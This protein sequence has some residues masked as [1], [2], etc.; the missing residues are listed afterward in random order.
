MFDYA[1]FFDKFFHF[2]MDIMN[3]YGLIFVLSISLYPY[4]YV[5]S[6]AFFLNQSNNII[7]ASKLLGASERKTFF[8]LICCAVLLQFENNYPSSSSSSLSFFNDNYY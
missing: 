3:H 8:K 4:V 7:E 1:G 5:A 2:K 6:R